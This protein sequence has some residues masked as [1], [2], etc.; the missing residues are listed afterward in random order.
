MP[1][2][3]AA[4]AR[5]FT[6]LRGPFLTSASSLVAP[7]GQ[8]FNILTLNAL[9]IVFGSRGDVDNMAGILQQL[10]ERRIPIDDTMVKHAVSAMVMQVLRPYMNPPF[11]LLLHG[12]SHL[13][14]VLFVY[15][16]AC[17]PSLLPCFPAELRLRGLIALGWL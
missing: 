6:P 16:T 3:I 1:Y 12:S 13:A 15:S 7:H 14:L 11:V 8:T 4:L 2:L 17:L 5:R 9:V 10:A